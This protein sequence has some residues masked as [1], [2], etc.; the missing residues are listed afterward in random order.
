MP[1]GFVVY[2]DESGDDGLRRVQPVDTHGS[3]EW[4]V[5]SAVVVRVERDAEA[6]QWVKNIVGKF[7]G[8]Q[9]SDLHYADLS[10]TKRRVACQ[11][12]A[13][14]PVRCFVVMS[15]KKNMR[16]YAN[17]KPAY[18][19][20]WFYWWCA[21]LLLERVTQFCAMR[22]LREYG[23]IRSLRVM[24]S[25]RGGMSY[26]RF[27]TY[28]NLLRFESEIGSLKLTA[29]DL[30]WR[31]IDLEQVFAY[32]HRQLADLQIADA[33]AGSFFQAVSQDNGRTCD[34]SNAQLLEP[35]M[36]RGP[37]G[38]IIGNGVKPMPTLRAMK[39]SMEQRLLFEFYGYPTKGWWAPR[40]HF[41]SRR[42]RLLSS[43]AAPERLG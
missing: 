21:R 39:L 25:Q 5:L 13:Q 7:T 22:S 30:D 9:R 24:F 14:L 6:I 41:A 11:D 37:R 31:V 26:S 19:R 16:S 27:R 20:N 43:A 23:E 17:P 18:E 34:P 1:V 33:V 8:A 32:D 40:P 3:S 2:I 15:N 36:Y 10:P 12:I 29:G 35:R 4:F 28:M 38:A 42:P